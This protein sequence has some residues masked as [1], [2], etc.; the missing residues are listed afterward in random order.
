MMEKRDISILLLRLIMILLAP[1]WVALS[2]PCVNSAEVRNIRVWP[3]PD[4][5]RVVFD[6]SA[7]VQYQ[8]IT[9]TNPPR[10]VLDLQ[11]S[12]LSTA[13]KNPVFTSSPIKA[14]RSSQRPDDKLRL[15][16]DLQKST[17]AHVFTLPPNATYGHRLVLDLDHHTSVVDLE[18]AVPYQPQDLSL[19]LLD[20]QRD[21]VIAIDA[22]HGGEDPGAVGP[23]IQGRQLHEKQV[24][25]AMAKYLRAMLTTE[26]GFSPVLIREGDYYVKLRKRTSK[27]RQ[28]KADVFISLHADA[29]RTTEPRGASVWTLSQRGATSE[30]G[31]W[32]ARNE[33]DADLIGGVSLDDKEPNLAK[34]LLD[35]S[36]TSSQTTSQGLATMVLQQ[37]GK[38]TR[39]HSKNV[40]QAGF[41]VLKSPDIA[42]I[43]VETG[44]ISNPTEARLL[45]QNSH[46][47]KIA[48]AIFQAIKAYFYQHPIDNTYLASVVQAQR[49]QKVYRVVSGDTLSNIARRYGISLKRLQQINTLSSKSTIKVGQKLTIPAS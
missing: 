2:S 12:T 40:Q 9:L 23:K 20:S 31:R 45:S 4:H 14:L 47:K 29:F 11:A 48:N 43:L 1:I 3:A 8:L 10:I 37:V 35:L 32:L 26:P 33:N 38:V 46:Q 30:M 13:V 25:L 5:T 27:A 44:F 17:A 42:S 16:M 36:M 6:I 24:V 34:T 21:I 7:P 39:L 22:G 19:G 15:V 18:N 49:N 41:A 28:L